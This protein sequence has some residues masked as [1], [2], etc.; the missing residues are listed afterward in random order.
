MNSCND[1]V[2]LDSLRSLRAAMHAALTRRAD[3]LC[4]LA[5]ALLCAGMV[6]SLPHLSVEAVHR[7]G[8]GSLYDALAAGRI[9]AAVLEDLLAAHPLPSGAPN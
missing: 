1:T 9:S 4:E 7:R 2:S 6:G 8:W 3:A 5:D